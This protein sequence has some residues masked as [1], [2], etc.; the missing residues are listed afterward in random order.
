DTI[1]SDITSFPRLKYNREMPF[2]KEVVYQDYFIP[3]DSVEI[4]KFY[5][6][7]KQWTNVI[8]LLKNNQ[9]KYDFIKEDTTITVQSYRIRDFE[10]VKNPYEGHYLHYNT[11]V[12]SSLENVPFHE[13][14]LIIS[15]DQPGIRYILETLEPSAV[16]SFFNWNFFDTILQQKEGFS[17]YVFEDSALY[18]LQN[19]SLLREEFTIKISEDEIFSKNWYDQLEWIFKKSKYYEKA[20]LQYPIYRIPKNRSNA[21][22]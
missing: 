18:L 21:N 8:D 4:P 15:T 7:K 11:K 19:D 12:T 9:I 17:P 16:D 22:N 20:H 3:S 14:D 13:G 10:T 2:E 6:V 5:I 1:I